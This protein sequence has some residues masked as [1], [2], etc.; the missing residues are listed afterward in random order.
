MRTATRPQI[1][2]ARRMLQAGTTSPEKIAANYGVSLR[3][4]YRW[5]DGNGVRLKA[6]RSDAGSVRSELSNEVWMELVAMITVD[7]WSVGEA[8][9]CLVA[10][11]RLAAGQ[12]SVS[13]IT[14]RLRE[15]GL[16]RKELKRHGPRA[17]VRRERRAP[18]VEH[19]VDGTPFASIYMNAENDLFYEPHDPLKKDAQHIGKT[20][21]HVFGCEDA[22]SRALYLRAYDGE[23]SENWMRFFHRAWSRKHNYHE[24]PFCGMPKILRCDGGSGLTSAVTQRSLAQVNI[25]IIPHGPGAAWAK[26]KIERVLQSYQTRCE[27]MTRRIKFTSFDELN[28]WLER[29]AIYYNNLVHGTTKETPF[30]R[31]NDIAPADLH[32]PPSEE[33]WRRICLRQ[34]AAIVY[35]DLT[36]R[37]G[38]GE[39]KSLG[40]QLPRL[41]PWTE[42]IGRRLTVYFTPHA[43]DPVLVDLP[44]VSGYSGG[45]LPA[46]RIRPGAQLVSSLQSNLV[47]LGEATLRLARD[48]SLEHLNPTAHWDAVTRHYPL[49]ESS[50]QRATIA[51]SELFRGRSYTQFEVAKA[52]QGGVDPVF[53]SPLNDQEIELIEQLMDE[54]GTADQPDGKMRISQATLDAAFGELR[55]ARANA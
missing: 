3:T 17:Y 34:D 25:K 26:G 2:E 8:L 38:V 13:W 18:N 39:D 52:G 14:R 46:A 12:I 19:Q 20:R 27:P 33:E 6:R 50:G 36:I 48:V 41:A 43:A 9:K 30:V 51:A 53:G 54:H 15:L 47:T 16:T 45:I 4:V 21:V 37:F 10:N 40:V 31:W 5:M 49:A 1:D 11:K 7:N 22:Y 28:I 55:R 44:A 42:Y 29:A 23:T 35:G 32:L 24:F